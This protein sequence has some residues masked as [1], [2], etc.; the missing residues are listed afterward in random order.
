[1]N[2][3]DLG[4]LYKSM[5]KTTGLCLIG[6]ASISA[7]PLFSGFVSK[8]MVIS[9]AIH[10]GYGGVWLALLFA[11]AGVVEHAGIK[12]P[13]FAFFA[14]DSGI[15]CKEAP[16]SMLIAM[17]IAAAFCIFN[18]SFPGAFLYPMLPYAVEYVPYTTAHVV[19]QLQLL[20]FAMLAVVWLMSSGRYPPELRSVNLDTDWVYRRLGPRAALAVARVAVFLRTGTVNTVLVGVN[21][22]VTGV[23]KHL[24]V[25][26]V[27]GRTWSTA[28][29]VIWV[30]LLLSF[31]L[32]LY[33]TK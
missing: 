1:M 31:F 16:R 25:T 27:M 7:F 26:G 30:A 19:A 20:F 11:S 17:T 8:S 21:S 18:G 3:S 4:G 32:I 6:A 24:G 22:T 29:S 9:A 13:F 28:G 15:R 2:G 5:P 10:E 14:H 12:I 23:R 33:Y